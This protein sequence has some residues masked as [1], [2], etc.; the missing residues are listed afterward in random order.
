MRLSQNF[1]VMKINFV[2]FH[3]TLGSPAPPHLGIV[4]V[5]KLLLRPLEQNDWR[6]EPRG[7]EIFG[8]RR[9]VM[10][11]ESTFQIGFWAGSFP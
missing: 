2:N 3:S 4:D 1:H 5:I 10:P 8:R 7:S 9:Q 6:P 11:D